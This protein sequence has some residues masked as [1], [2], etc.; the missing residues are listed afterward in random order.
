MQFINKFEKPPI[1]TQGIKRVILFFVMSI[2]IFSSN[3]AIVGAIG[4]D[5][6]LLFDQD[7]NYFDIDFCATEE[8]DGLSAGSGKADGASFPKLNPE[9]M[10]EAIDKYIVQTNS[11]SRMKDLG[12]TIVASAENSN[13]NPFLIVAIAQKESSL[14][15]PSD[16]NVS[17][18]NNS[19]G[20]TATSSQ[21]NFS[22]A[23]LWYK[24][25]SVKASVDHTAAENKDA[26]GGGDIAAYIR[27]QYNDKIDKD[28]LVSL[29]MEYAPPF[30]NDTDKYIADIRSWTGK[31]IRLTKESTSAS[32]SKQGGSSGG[33]EYKA[34]GNIP[35]DGKT[36]TASVYG[37]I[38]GKD[39]SGKYVEYLGGM[40]GGALDERGKPLKGRAVV[41]E[42]SGNKAL[43]KLPYG[44]KIEIRYKGKSVIAEVSDNGPGAGDHSDV[45]LWREVADLLDF[46][47][48][49]ENVTIRGVDNSTPTTSID[50]DAASVE[51]EEKSTTKGQ[52]ICTTPE[53][54][55]SESKSGAKESNEETIYNFYVREGYTPEQAAAFVGNYYQES[56]Y[57]PT[58]VNSI[59]ATGIAQWL[60]GR[61]TALQNFAQGKSKS[62]TSL[63][64]QLDFSIHE[65][66]GSESGAN[67]AIKSISGS[68]KI[69]VERL[70]YIIR[71]KYERPGESEARDDIRIK[72]ALEV[73]S[74]YGGGTGGTV[75]DS[76]GES[77]CKEGEL[78][79]EGSGVS[80]GKLAW[81]MESKYPIT[82][83]YGQRWGRLHGG[84]D[85]SAPAGTP[86]KAADGGTV[87]I[88]GPSSGFGNTVVI[89]HSDGLWTLYAHM[90]NGSI[91]VR[92]GQKVDQ[93]QVIGQ[94]NNTGASRGDHLH[95]N[96][97]T[98]GGASYNDAKDP[99]K[100]LPKDTLRKIMPGSTN[101][102]STLT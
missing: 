98:A 84:I 59:G 55:S 38:G 77:D 86:I 52:C 57:D 32:S 53:S 40:E 100:Y 54:G 66:K 29:M 102:P 6:N 20:R 91:K 17:K 12:E 56:K 50:G 37:T 24:W 97:Q 83:C 13:I 36:Y 87:E 15:N 1:G 2:F 5:Q 42:M 27:A 85:I 22:G 43:G 67:S 30:E 47:Y 72:K 79:A 81:P 39:K 68:G 28:D 58:L 90:K 74:K 10:A 64:V 41:A 88:A 18:G 3:L 35:L 70:T 63:L 80:S 46:P 49:K 69:A 92:T 21:P 71:T 62:A 99:L 23:R 89:K 48:G 82:S 25:T 33:V 14:S 4:S 16:Y 7:I 31:M 26:T 8:D 101:C 11:S 44:E 60:G 76:G 65:L 94:V 19:F 75:I 73:Y 9:A 96:V 78:S 34:K 93:G 61:L 51:T 45:D 95:F